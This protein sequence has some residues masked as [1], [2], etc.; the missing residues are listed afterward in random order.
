MKDKILKKIKC[1]HCKELMSRDD[2]MYSQEGEVTYKVT[3]D[4]KGVPIEWEQD[5]FITKDDGIFYHKNCGR[6]IDKKTLKA[7]GVNW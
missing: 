2:L 1:P 5:E 7:L 4:E 6:E 3:F